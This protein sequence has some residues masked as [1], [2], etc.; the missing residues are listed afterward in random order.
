L[1]LLHTFLMN[2]HSPKNQLLFSS[3]KITFNP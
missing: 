3:G 2:I 1:G